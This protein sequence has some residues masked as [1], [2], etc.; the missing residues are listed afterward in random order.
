MARKSKFAPPTRHA[1]LG[2]YSGVVVSFTEATHFCF[3]EGFRRGPLRQ[4][5]KAP[6]PSSESV[7]GRNPPGAEVRTCRSRRASSASTGGIAWRARARA[8]GSWACT[9]SSGYDP[10]QARPREIAG[11]FEPIVVI[12]L[13]FVRL[14]VLL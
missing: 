3:C 13:A 14:L 2:E 7:Q 5:G 10:W 11:S 8:G 1:E 9:R 12:C 4:R 6:G